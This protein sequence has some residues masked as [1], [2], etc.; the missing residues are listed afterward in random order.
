MKKIKDIISKPSQAIRAMCEGLI[1][2]NKRTDFIV[3]MDTFGSYIDGI[4]YGCAATCAIQNITGRNLTAGEQIERVTNR[5][6]VLRLDHE[7]LERFEFIIDD[8]RRGN[9]GLGLIRLFE[10]FGFEE[11]EALNFERYFLALPYMERFDL[12]EIKEYKKFAEK[13]EQFG[14]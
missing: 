2:Q 12:E 14:Y 1:D 11:S 5:S 9:F 4:C 13:L 6:K 10:Y 7:D 8:V 3:N